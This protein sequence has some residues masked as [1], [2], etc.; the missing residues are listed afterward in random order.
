MERYVKNRESRLCKAFCLGDGSLLEKSYIKKGMI[1]PTGSN[2]YEIFTKETKEHGE[3]AMAG[4]YVKI[5]CE[6]EIYPN[7]REYFL[8]NHKKVESEPSGELFEQKESIVWVAFWE[9]FE[10]LTEKLPEELKFLIER[11]GLKVNTGNE[12]SYY[13]ADIWGT[14]CYAKKDA[15]L[16]IHR[17]ER[18]DEGILTGVGFQFVEKG[19]FENSYEKYD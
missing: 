9:D 10:V 11:K 5:G 12:E 19:I 2:R 7:K 6:G 8:K 18:N 1:M 16:V 4:D 13:E 14:H 17:M 15:A 3:E